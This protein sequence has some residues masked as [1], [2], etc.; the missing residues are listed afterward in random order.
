VSSVFLPAQLRDREKIQEGLQKNKAFMHWPAS[1]LSELTASSRLCRYFRGARILAAGTPR[2]ETCVIVSGRILLVRPSGSFGEALGLLGSGIVLAGVPE[3]DSQAEALVL[4][5]TVVIHLDSSLLLELLERQPLMWS[6]L[7]QAL[8][9]QENTLLAG[10]IGRTTGSVSQKV[11]SALLQQCCLSHTEDALES[12]SSCFKLSQDDCAALLQLSRKT[13][14][15]E[16]KLLES[17][18]LIIRGYK[19][20]IVPDLMALASFAGMTHRAAQP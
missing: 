9:V 10:L 13:V 11:A 7:I 19:L 5:T 6:D 1:Q 20:I 8:L 3:F 18:G 17:K 16:L 2:H 14:G 15:K 12:N 4:D